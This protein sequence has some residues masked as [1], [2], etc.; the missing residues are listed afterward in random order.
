MKISARNVWS[1]KVKRVVHGVVT[2][3]VTVELADGLEVTAAITRG[4]AERLAL[5]QGRE[6][7]VIVKAAD[8][9]I[10]VEDE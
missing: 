6:C 10:A 7:S 9:M 1:G 4:S 5:K 8:V 2:S 3:E